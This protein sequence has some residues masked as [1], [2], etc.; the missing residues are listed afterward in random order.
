MQNRN[1]HR[2]II[3]LGLLMLISVQGLKAQTTGKIVGKVLAAESG[4]PL[5]G[6]NVVIQG[7]SRGAA[8]NVNGEFYIIN[9]PPGSYNVAVHFMGY[10]RHIIENLVVS[11]NRSTHIEAVL[12][13]EA[14]QGEAIVVTATK[15]SYMKD[16]TSSIKNVS[17]QQIAVL[18]AQ[19][20]EDVIQLQA[21]IVGGHVRGGRLGEVSYLIDGMQVDE[22]FGGERST[23]ELEKE[24]VQ[25]LEVIT[26][27]FD[28]EYGKAMS[29]IIN[30]VTK[31]G[32]DEFHGSAH[33]HLGNYMTQNDDIFIGN[34]WSDASRI[35]DYKFQ[36]SGPIWKKRLHFISN[37]RYEND[38][39][40]LNGVRRFNVHDYTNFSEAVDEETPHR[41]YDTHINGVR[42]Y[43]EATG[44]SAFVPMSEN[45]TLSLF[46]KL[47][48]KPHH[49]FK[50]SLT[51]TWNRKSA[52]HYSHWWKYNPDGRASQHT[53]SS[54]LA[55][56]VN[57]I[58]NNS[59]FHDFKI[60]LSKDWSGYYLYE[61]PFDSRYV[62][63]YYMRGEGGFLT[64]GTDKSH[65]QRESEQLALKYDL[66]WQAGVHHNFKTGVQ[67]TQYKIK[68]D[69]IGVR[70]V[71]WDQLEALSQYYFDE[72][73]QEV[74]FKP[75]EAELVP[76]ENFGMDNYV[77]RPF[78]ISAYLRD[79]LEYDD[80]VINLGVRYDYFNANSWYPSNRRNPA[81]QGQYED[82]AMMSDSLDAKPQIQ[83]SPRFGLSYTLGS[84]AV[85]H[86]SYG[87]FFQMPPMY[88]LYSN[89]RQLI[90]TG[91]FMTTHGNPMI[92][93]QKTVKYEMGLWQEVV[94]GLGLE[95]SIYYSDIYDL[96]TSVVWTTYN[97]VKYGVYSNKDYA[98]S[99]G[100]EV[101]MDYRAGDIF[102]GLNYTL[103]Y[104][105]GNA[106][107]P[108][109]TYNRLAQNL[110]PIP[111][112]I[113]L[114][115]DQRHTLNLNVSYSQPRYSVSLTGYFN[116]G[117]PYSFEPVQESYLRRQ[118]LLPNNSRMPQTYSLNMQ[119]HYDVPLVRGMKMRFSLY[120]SNLLD[121]LN[122]RAVNPLTGQAYSTILRPV[123][124][125]TFR[126]NYNTVLDA[127]Q[128]PA[129][130]SPPREV[131][132]GV[133]FVF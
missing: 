47:T 81:N 93:P 71:Q 49:D 116:S 5:F 40:Y 118:N 132:L 133:G 98:N 10:R 120:V 51:Y 115:W 24:V 101:K 23:V 36:L 43:S 110:D 123:E 27:T 108:N 54:L 105:R 7:T 77:K 76:A 3:L 25:D 109:S 28:A 129:M 124:Q 85:L 103:Q 37:I 68:N 21:G 75:W 34:Q 91:D 66:N 44:D 86:F 39:G 58:L 29:G 8:T 78:D 12:E 84:A 90:P 50:T 69:P 30:M 83:I 15:L 87:H 33:V 82:P 48:F 17:S 13:I 9:V 45:E 4:A 95:V 102:L 38:R 113:P 14:V 100:L 41:L 26:G 67:Y 22:T 72:E 73:T 104:T 128:N 126:S 106:D 88:A 112:L 55:F 96:L 70:D 65:S 125:E 74:V 97:E 1:R 121:R 111:A 130:F 114:A 60:S 62:S 35:Q 19:D 56:Q 42:Y 92:N 107:N 117:Y 99:K 6:A 16:Q 63:D 64:G 131:K 18:P 46:G 32:S 57:H 53:E 94:P 122:D 52:Q 31:D 89:H 127:Y 20:M 119:G 59:A 79:K 11:V 80:L 61:N 2:W